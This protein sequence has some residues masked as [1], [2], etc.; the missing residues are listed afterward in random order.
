MSSNNS[1]PAIDKLIG[2]ENFSTW[3]FAVQTYL[4]HEDLHKYLDGTETD[5]KKISK[6]KTKIILLLDPINY[7]H[8][9]DCADA[10][11]V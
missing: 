10:K 7:V 6:A 1:L 9:Q 4:E 11:S 8:K 3:K 5:Q 2:R